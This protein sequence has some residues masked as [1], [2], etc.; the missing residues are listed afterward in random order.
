MLAQTWSREMSLAVDTPSATPRS[1]SRG[2]CS[3]KCTGTSNAK[4]AKSSESR[5]NS[6]E[7][8]ARR[9]ALATGTKGTSCSCWRCL[10]LGPCN[11][12]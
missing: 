4:G 11:S 3:T 2:R 8:A 10:K 1:R 9:V 6:C 5:T 12:Q 7:G